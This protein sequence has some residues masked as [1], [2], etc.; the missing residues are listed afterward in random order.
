MGTLLRLFGNA[1]ARD[2]GGWMLEASTQVLV[3]VHTDDAFGGGTLPLDPM[4]SAEAALAIERLT[5]AGLRLTVAVQQRYV[6]FREVRNTVAYVDDATPAEL[7]RIAAEMIRKG[8]PI[9]PAPAVAL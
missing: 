9:V 6:P 1:R 5:A 3:T 4:S 2:F 7:E 8:V